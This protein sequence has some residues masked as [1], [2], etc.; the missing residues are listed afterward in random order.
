MNAR[1]FQGDL[2]F[3]IRVLVDIDFNPWS[4]GRGSKHWLKTVGPGSVF[5]TKGKLFWAL[6]WEKLVSQ[7]QSSVWAEEWPGRAKTDDPIVINSMQAPKRQTSSNSLKRHVKE[8]KPLIITF[9]KYQLIQ[10][11]QCISNT[12][13]LEV[14]NSGTWDYHFLQ[15]LRLINQ[16][17]DDFPQAWRM[18]REK[19]WDWRIKH[20][21]V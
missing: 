17:E 5:W 21:P 19:W 15:N 6:Q 7:L 2:K 3:L 16:I 1:A 8:K 10:P 12:P 18:Y 13:V 14:Q 9:L 11:C 4:L 20:W